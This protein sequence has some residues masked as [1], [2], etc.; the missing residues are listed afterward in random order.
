MP[1]SS[2]DCVTCSGAANWRGGSHC[3]EPTGH[4]LLAEYARLIV[5]VWPTPDNAVLTLRLPRTYRRLARAMT[6]CCTSATTGY[7]DHQLGELR[8]AARPARLAVYDQPNSTDNGVGVHRSVDRSGHRLGLGRMAARLQAVLKSAT[9]EEYPG[10]QDLYNRD[11]QPRRVSL[12]R[13]HSHSS[14]AITR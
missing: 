5:V 3:A 8:R 4:E 6:T 10:E 9:G 12:R 2:M 13:I 11:P 14:N 7:P 1:C